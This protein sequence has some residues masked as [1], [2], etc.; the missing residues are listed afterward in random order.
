MENTAN[1]PAET[2]DQS[3]RRCGTCCR[4]GGP[5]LHCED[6][7][8]FLNETLAPRH[9]YTIRRGETVYHNISGTLVRTD[10]ELLKIKEGDDGR[11][12]S[13]FLLSENACSMYDR[14][15]LQCR[16]LNCRDTTELE[17]VLATPVLGRKDLLPSGSSLTDLLRTHDER[18]LPEELDDMVKEFRRSG[19]DVIARRIAALLHRDDAFRKLVAKRL[20]IDPSEMDFFFGRPLSV[21]A[22]L[23]GLAIMEEVDETRKA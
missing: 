4:K 11:S 13:F 15:P 21:L 23:S 19:E 6:L 17:R 8:L 14:R 10:R 5:T 2:E 16:V 20:S 12:C 1:I 18:C 22:K 3:C 9:I 7:K